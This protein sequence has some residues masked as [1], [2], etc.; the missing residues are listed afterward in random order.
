MMHGQRNIK[1]ASSCMSVCPHGTTRSRM[2]QLVPCCISIL[3]YL[4][5]WFTVKHKSCFYCIVYIFYTY[6]L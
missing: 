4:H 1:L 5:W 6:F 3:L 2:E